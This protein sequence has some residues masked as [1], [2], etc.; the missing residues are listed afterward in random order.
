L[1]FIEREEMINDSII[2]TYLDFLTY[3]LK[4]KL[5]TII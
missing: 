5:F 3:A 1:P 2:D 4:K